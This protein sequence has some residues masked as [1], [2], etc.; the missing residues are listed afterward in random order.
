M[1]QPALNARLLPSS[2][3]VRRG[4]GHGPT[5]RVSKCQ[6]LRGPGQRNYRI[7]Y[8]VI[9]MGFTGR[10]VG[11]A[12]G[13]A[14]RHRALTHHIIRRCANP[15][16]V[17]CAKRHPACLLCPKPGAG[18]VRWSR[19]AGRDDSGGAYGLAGRY[20][21]GWR[22]P[23]LKPGQ[24]KLVKAGSDLG[25]STALHD[26]PAGRERSQPASARSSPKSL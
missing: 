16:R 15:D 4:L 19:G 9:P 18:I 5:G 11:G 7:S 20:A 3:A 10:Q 21:P 13:S 6:R 24:A 22:D 14:A 8:I 12:G 2:G 1:P 23:D 25:A 26:Q 17:I